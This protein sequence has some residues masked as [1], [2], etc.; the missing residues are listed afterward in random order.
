M[1]FRRFKHCIFCGFCS[2]FVRIPFGFK[3]LNTIPNLSAE[4]RSIWCPNKGI[5]S[6]KGINYITYGAKAQLPTPSSEFRWVIPAV[7]RRVLTSHRFFTTP[8]GKENKLGN[9]F[10][11]SL[12]PRTCYELSEHSVLHTTTHRFGQCSLRATRVARSQLS[13]QHSLTTRLY[14]RGALNLKCGTSPSALFLPS[15]T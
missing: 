2:G 13:D 3:R 6:N 14:T 8:W 7:W 11:K 1:E 10:T 4:S 9:S 5:S 12:I 15:S